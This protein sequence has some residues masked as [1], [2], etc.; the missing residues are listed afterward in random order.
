MRPWLQSYVLLSRTLLR[1]GLNLSPCSSHSK[2]AREDNIR[3]LNSWWVC[4][5]TRKVTGL[6]YPFQQFVGTARNPYRRRPSSAPPSWSPEDPDGPTPG[7]VPLMSS[8][9]TS[10]SGDR[11]TSV[12]ELHLVPKYGPKATTASVH[13]PFLPL[14]RTPEPS[15]PAGK[16]SC[17]PAA[18]G[19]GCNPSLLSA[20]A[21]ERTTVEAPGN[22][23]K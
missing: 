21:A 2:R 15:V 19:N 7:S 17:H 8:S 23:Q 22:C 18:T 11:A 4:A 10:P 16:S 12:S 3:Q 5:G 6:R 20:I 13:D 1:K 14:C 9:H